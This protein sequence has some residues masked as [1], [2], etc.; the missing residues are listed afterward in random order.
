MTTAML[1]MP[2]PK[3]ND[4]AVKIDAYVAR[5]ARILAAYE[6]TTIAEIVS[7][8]MRP[9]LMKRLDKLGVPYPPPPE[10]PEDEET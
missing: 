9:I 1:T 3:R 4:V 8:G 2:K 6:D 5:L 7:E 10:P